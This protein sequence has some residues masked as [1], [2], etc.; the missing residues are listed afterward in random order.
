VV[1]RPIA[2]AKFMQSFLAVDTTQASQDKTLG[3]VVSGGIVALRGGTVPGVAP[4]GLV[5]ASSSRVPAL[6]ALVGSNRVDVGTPKLGIAPAAVA[7]LDVSEH[8]ISITRSELD[9]KGKP[10][11][12][13]VS[14]HF[15][16]T[17]QDSSVPAALWGQA[18][19][20]ARDAKPIMAV[21]GLE[22]RPAAPVQPGPGLD[23]LVQD[24]AFD[25]PAM[26]IAAQALTAH[27]RIKPL[28]EATVL[29]LADLAA[30]GLDGSTLQWVQPPAGRVRIDMLT[31]EMEAA[32]G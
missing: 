2:L 25:P 15:H 28:V 21:N 22:L 30:L 8:S 26:T 31:G 4:A 29:P 3:I 17:P 9:A 24:L 27:R 12:I 11:D 7:S 6:K 16:A 20:V 18:M 14:H 10:N 13:E 23:K 5:L 19:T 1:P 32:H